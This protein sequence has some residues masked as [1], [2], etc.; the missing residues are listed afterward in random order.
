MAAALYYERQTPNLGLDFISS[1][2]LACHRLVAFP[3]SGHGFGSRL[4]RVLVPGF[5]YALL[6]RIEP[7]Q[8]LIV[9]VA[10]LRRRPGYWRDR[11]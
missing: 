11:T 10:H 4:R 1:V 5:P 9:A 3:E 8:I 6:Y 2:E 7:D